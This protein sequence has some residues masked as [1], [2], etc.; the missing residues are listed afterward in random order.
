VGDKMIVNR[1]GEKI[2]VVSNKN[3]DKILEIDGVENLCILIDME[4]DKDKEDYWLMKMDEVI[5]E[6]YNVDKVEYRWWM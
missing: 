3:V 1:N 2:L 5:R 4:G 6:Y